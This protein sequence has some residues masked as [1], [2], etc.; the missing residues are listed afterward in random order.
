M[1]ATDRH[2][3]AVVFCC[4]RNYFPLALFMAWQIDHHNP[5]R[6][7]DIL[8]ASRDDLQLPDW[9]APLKIGLHRVSDPPDAVMAALKRLPKMARFPGTT[10][11]LDR[12]MLPRELKDRYRRLLALDC[13]MYV[14]GGDFDR[15]LDI[16]IGPHPVGAVLDAPFLY[17]ATYHA[18]EYQLAG[19]GAAP[20]CNSGLLLIDTAAYVAQDVDQRSFDMLTSHPAAIRYTDQSITNLALWGGFA[21]LAP[22][23]NWQN[24]KRLPLLSLTYPVFITHFIGNDKPD[25][26]LPRTLDARYNL[27]YREF[28]GRHFPELL[29]KVPAPQSPDPLRLREVFG[30]AMEHLAARKTALSLLARYPDPYVALI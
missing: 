7:F 23:W 18:R 12:N 26:A 19:L 25:R 15:L 9:A 20:Y 21:Q 16:D 24:S 6:G 14:S 11:P 8:I 28:F 29:P 5:W 30:I 3:K 22:A 1:S 10:T 2:D 17:E 27:A 13:D 4:D